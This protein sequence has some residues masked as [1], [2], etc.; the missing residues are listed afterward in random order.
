[1]KIF[2]HENFPHWTLRDFTIL[3]TFDNKSSKILIKKNANKIGSPDHSHLRGI[4]EG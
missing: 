3:Y 4:N 1:M 2:L